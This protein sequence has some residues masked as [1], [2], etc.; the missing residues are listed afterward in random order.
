MMGCPKGSL[1]LDNAHEATRVRVVVENRWPG[2][3]AMLWALR[4]GEG[5]IA[6]PK[7]YPGVEAFE[8]H[9]RAFFNN[10]EALCESGR[11]VDFAVFGALYCFR[12]GLELWLKGLSQIHLLD[13]VLSAIL[14]GKD[15]EQVTEVAQKG[16]DTKRKRE[17]RR[18]ELIRALC[19]VRNVDNGLRYPACHQVNIGPEFAQERLSKGRIDSHSLSISWPISIHG[20]DL[21]ALWSETKDLVR[22]RHAVAHENNE[23][24]LGGELLDP[25]EI[26]ALCDLLGAWDNDGDAFRYPCSLTGDWFLHL[27]SLN[28]DKLAKMASAM[29]ST[30][31]CYKRQG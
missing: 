7:I 20:H 13:E 25:D 29:E 6:E 10:A 15:L 5:N 8:D 2:A 31:L 28:L 21:R 24:Y 30:V 12:H 18:N 23:I 14:E 22:E 26:E 4:G 3:R 11:A 9:A 1:R 16:C 27:P 19:V 17:A